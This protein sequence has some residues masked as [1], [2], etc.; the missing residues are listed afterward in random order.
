MLA[1]ISHTALSRQ[2]SFE[3]RS[4]ICLVHFEADIDELLVLVRPEV[5]DQRYI[6]TVNSH[7]FN[8]WDSKL[9]HL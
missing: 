3:D 8:T 4:P 2:P 7:S 1:V 9:N 6:N 5:K